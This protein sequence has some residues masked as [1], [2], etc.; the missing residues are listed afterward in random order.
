MTATGPLRIPDAMKPLLG[1]ST[2]AYA[3][4]AETKNPISI[5]TKVRSLAKCVGGTPY[6][7][8]VEFCSGEKGLPRRIRDGHASHF[9]PGGMKVAVQFEGGGKPM[10]IEGRRAPRL[11]RP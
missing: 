5:A 7:R 8:V 9:S 3:L 4:G 11:R 2:A 6:G 1:A 10:K